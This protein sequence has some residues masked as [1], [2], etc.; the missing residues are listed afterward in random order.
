MKVFVFAGWEEIVWTGYAEGIERV[1]PLADAYVVRISTIEG[2]DTCDLYQERALWGCL[3][4]VQPTKT[5]RIA[6]TH[7][8]CP[9]ST[10][11]SNWKSVQGQHFVWGSSNAQKIQPE[12]FDPAA[13]L[14]S[15]QGELSWDVPTSSTLFRSLQ[16]PSW[17]WKC[18]VD[19]ICTVAGYASEGSFSERWRFS[20][21]C[22]DIS[23]GG[24]WDDGDLSKIICVLL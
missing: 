23:R 5:A 14:S 19:R 6:P 9:D 11:R 12:H 4:P 24:D 10:H 15:R 16:W 18:Q 22:G 1:R 20:R 3:V 17:A 8:W 7:S 13:R 21:P 2:R